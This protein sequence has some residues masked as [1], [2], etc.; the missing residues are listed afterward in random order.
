MP[1][2]SFW[3]IRTQ[4]L[5]EWVELAF[6]LPYVSLNPLSAT[7]PEDMQP[8]LPVDLNERLTEMIGQG[9]HTR[10]H[11]IDVMLELQQHFGFV[12]DEAIREASRLLGMTPLELEELATFYDFLYREPVG[13]YVIRVCDSTICWMEG[14]ESLLDHLRRRLSVDIGGTTGDGLF[15]LLPVCCIGYC[16]RGPAMLINGKVYGTLTRDKVDHILD[17]LR[18]GAD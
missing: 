2:E 16:D 1:T 6:H 17:E 15:T 12:S 10:E 7:F 4:T 8:M 5:P 14:E 13:R 9:E 18:N 11:A 3:S